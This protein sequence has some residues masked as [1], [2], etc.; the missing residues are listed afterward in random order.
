LA[1]SHYS[2]AD[3]IAVPAVLAQQNKLTEYAHLIRWAQQ[4]KQ[5]PAV[6][7]GMAE[8]KQEVSHAN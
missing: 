8:P 2:I 4:L 6:M 7:R 1:G 5:R 3:I